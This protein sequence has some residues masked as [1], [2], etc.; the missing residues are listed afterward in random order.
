MIVALDIMEAKAMKLARTVYSTQ[1]IES[2]IVEVWQAGRPGEPA[3][4]GLGQ[5]GYVHVQI[6]I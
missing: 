2:V 6:S 1:M 3:L 4:G 5:L